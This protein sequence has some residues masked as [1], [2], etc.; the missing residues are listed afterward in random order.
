[1][2]RSIAGGRALALAV[3]VV[4][5]GCRGGP[6]SGRVVDCTKLQESPTQLASAEDAV[7]DLPWGTARLRLRWLAD[8]EEH[9]LFVEEATAEVYHPPPPISEGTWSVQVELDCS[10]ESA[11]VVLFQADP[12]EPSLLPGEYPLNGV[13]F[14]VP[15]L[16]QGGRV[17]EST[18]EGT[19]TVTDV[20]DLRAS[21]FVTGSGR[22]VLLSYITQGDIG[23][24]AEVSELA[25]N[26]LPVFE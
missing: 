22:T 5:A 18:F 20:T 21:G 3:L 26:R 13:G 17:L 24:E 4:G 12:A 15:E 1:M 7:D 11:A 9:D 25:F 14:D 19:A 16:E 10:P 6:G 23:V 8:G 2:G